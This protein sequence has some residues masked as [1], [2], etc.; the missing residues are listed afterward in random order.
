MM[1][2]ETKA[3]LEMVGKRRMD[4]IKNFKSTLLQHTLGR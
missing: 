4:A 3:I 2:Q 1:R